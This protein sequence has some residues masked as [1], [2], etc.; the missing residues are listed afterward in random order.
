[1]D[2]HERYWGLRDSG[3][4]SEYSWGAGNVPRGRKFAP[5]DSGGAYAAKCPPVNPDDKGTVRTGYA[6]RQIRA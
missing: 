2:F 4:A 3:E 6:G 5:P 1:M